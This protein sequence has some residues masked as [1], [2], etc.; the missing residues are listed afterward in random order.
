MKFSFLLSFSIATVAVASGPAGNFRQAY[1]PLFH[2]QLP[3]NAQEAKKFATEPVHR[4]NKIAID[5]TGLDHTPVAPGEH[6]IFGEQLGPGRA[7]RAMAIVHVAIFDAINAAQGK[8]QSFT[9]IQSASQP[10]STAAAVAQAAHDTL[11]SVFTSQRP[12]FDQELADD[13]LGNRPRETNRG[14]R[15]GFAC[16]GWRGTTRTTHRHRL[17]SQQPSRSLAAGPH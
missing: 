16:W 3:N 4:W 15:P 17:F 5:A 10:Y 9:G 8:Y 14:R 12:A 1:G 13:L 2:P 7:S 6:R 11:S